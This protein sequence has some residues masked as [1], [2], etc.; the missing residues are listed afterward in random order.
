MFILRH[1]QRHILTRWPL[2]AWPHHQLVI[3]AHHISYGGGRS[4]K[5]G[6]YGWL[7]EMG[8][9]ALTPKWFVSAWFDQTLLSKLE[10]LWTSRTHSHNLKVMASMHLKWRNKWCQIKWHQNHLNLI[11]VFEMS[12]LTIFTEVS[13]WLVLLSRIW[14]E[15]VLHWSSGY[16][17][18]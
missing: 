18:L 8:L 4:T 16:S 17:T 15:V 14:G 10:F 5:Q 3:L 6:Y 12:K 9:F 2:L 13:I 1:L 11:T 7:E